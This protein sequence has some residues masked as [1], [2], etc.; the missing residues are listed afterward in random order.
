M[1]FDFAGF[2]FF[3]SLSKLHWNPLSSIS[4]LLVVSPRWLH[5]VTVNALMALSSVRLSNIPQRHQALLQ[6]F[7]RVDG[8]FSSFLRCA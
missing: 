8:I 1:L 6:V 5:V 2:S 7:C 4:L 3:S